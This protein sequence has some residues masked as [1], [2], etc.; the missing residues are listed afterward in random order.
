[1]A[2]W[3][4]PIEEEEEVVLGRLMPKKARLTREEIAEQERDRQKRAR[5]ALARARLKEIITPLLI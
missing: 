5:Q 2:E 3:G 4:L 1:M